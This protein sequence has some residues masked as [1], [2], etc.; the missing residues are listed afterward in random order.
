MKKIISLVM[1]LI[2]SFTLAIPTYAVEECKKESLSQ[3]LINLIAE[4]KEAVKE[5]PES[6]AL[7]PQRLQEDDRYPDNGSE[8]YVEEIEDLYAELSQLY[9]DIELAE[10]GIAPESGKSVEDLNRRVDEVKRALEQLGSVEL[11]PAELYDVV[12]PPA[13]TAN[14]SFNAYGPLNHTYKGKS[15]SYYKITAIPKNENSVLG[16]NAIAQME[17]ATKVGDYAKSIFYIYVQKAIGLVQ[18]VQW[19][20]YELLFSG[21]NQYMETSSNYMLALYF[22]TTGSYYFV[23]NKYGV[24]TQ[25]LKHDLCRVSEGHNIYYEGG[26]TLKQKTVQRTVE[27]DLPSGFFGTPVELAITNVY[28]LGEYSEISEVHQ[29]LYYRPKSKTDNTRVLV[30]SVTPPT[31]PMSV[32]TIK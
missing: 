11:E 20:P 27:G 5:E 21:S 28:R 26:N 32:Y 24:Y 13:N 9:L 12:K 4:K 30:K 7:A 18:Y 8:R 6:K 25:G 22:R 3:E 15:Y 14:V 1:A 31:S 29:F 10:E 17:K 16:L 19:T 23:A 2:M